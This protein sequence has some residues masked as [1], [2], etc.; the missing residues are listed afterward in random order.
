MDVYWEVLCHFRICTDINHCSSLGHAMWARYLFPNAWEGESIVPLKALS[1]AEAEH[2]MGKHG[3]IPSDVSQIDMNEFVVGSLIESYHYQ[4][5]VILSDRALMAGFLMIWLKRCILPAEKISADVV[6]P[7]VLL[8]FNHSIA[9]LPALMAGIHRGLR[10]LVNSFMGLHK[11]TPQPRTRKSQRS[12]QGSPGIAR[13][14]VET[15]TS[16]RKAILRVE[17]AY[18][19]LMAWFVMH[20]PCLMDIPHNP[21][22]CVPFLQRLEGCSWAHSYLPKV[23]EVLSLYQ[24]YLV[25][26]RLPDTPGSGGSYHDVSSKAGTGTSLSREAFQWLINIR[27]GYLVYVPGRVPVLELYTPSRFARQLGYDQLCVGNPNKSLRW[28]GNLFD[29]ARAW[30]FNIAGCTGARFNIPSERGEPKM[31]MSYCAWYTQVN[32]APD[33]DPQGALMANIWA[34]YAAYSERGR[35]S[36]GLLEYC[37]CSS[38]GG[39]PSSAPPS[40]PVLR[41]R[42]G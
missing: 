4:S 41:R 12:S 6:L 1:V 11:K 15:G 37:E 34:Y 10:D 18:T 24:S 39:E 31:A 3:I 38:L 30:F 7:A 32:R 14:E 40:E 22:L 8:C 28:K 2:R 20:C 5:T 17:M 26:C 36:K 35:L 19:H 9:L 16:L 21:S 42:K 25:F 27:P 23:R 33:F 29:A 13:E